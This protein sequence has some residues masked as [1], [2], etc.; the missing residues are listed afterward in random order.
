M[1]L[2]EAI[3][4]SLHALRTQVQ[5][6]KRVDPNDPSLAGWGQFLDAEGHKEQ[7]GPYGTCAAI[8]LNSILT[9]GVAED[10]AVVSQIEKFW[11]DP[12]ENKKLRY[13]N[14]RIAFLVLALAN[15]ADTKLK[16]VL[17]EAVELLKG[18]QRADGSWGDWADDTTSAPPRVETTAWI[19]LALNRAGAASDAIGAAQKYLNSLVSGVGNSAAMSSFATGALLITLPKGKATTKLLASAHAALREIER[20]DLGQITFFDYLENPGGNEP[21]R[22]RRD[23]LCYPLV[24]PYALLTAGVTKQSGWLSG[25]LS[26][27]KRLKLSDT[28]KV[29]I[30]NGSYFRLP[31][32]SFPSTVD[33]AAVALSFDKLRHSEYA[34]DARFSA[35]R[36]FISW[37]TKSFV[38]RVAVPLTLAFAALVSIQDPKLLASPIPQSWT[39][40]EKSKVTAYLGENEKNIRLIASM[41][42]FF[43]SSMPGRILTFVRERLWY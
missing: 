1:Q 36:P 34:L 20:G 5:A 28:L 39:W 38:F 13:Q 18:R 2:T 32:A 27:P 22:V 23:Y 29:M 42:L 12:A 37:I 9:P 21:K 31:G 33:Q 7:I 4:P 40:I 35:L 25:L 26:A 17:Q 15:C 16:R 8:L 19:L 24:L 43:V 14:V 30:G 10:A 41:F 11:D 3:E 6:A